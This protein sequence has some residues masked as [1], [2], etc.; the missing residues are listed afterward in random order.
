MATNPSSVTLPTEGVKE[1]TLRQLA[2]DI[3]TNLSEKELLK[4]QEDETEPLCKML[5]KGKASKLINIVSSVLQTYY[6]S[7]T[8]YSKGFDTDLQMTFLIEKVKDSQKE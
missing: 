7:G 1:E 3:V 6:S 4:K 2:K 8:S 5:I